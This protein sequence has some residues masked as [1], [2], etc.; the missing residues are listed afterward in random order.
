M[1][2]ENIYNETYEVL[3]NFKMKK[4]SNRSN[5]SGVKK[6]VQWGRNKNTD[7]YDRVGFP[8]E[9]MNFGLVKKRFCNDGNPNIKF[10]QPIQYG[11]NNKK[12]PEIYEQLKKLIEEIDPNFEYDCITIN[13]NFKCRPHYDRNNKSPSLIV[14]FGNYEGG[15]LVIEGEEFDIKNKPLIFNGSI[16]KHWTLEWNGDRFSVIYFKIT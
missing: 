8:C 3:K 16:A 1:C 7:K 15:E 9:S 10:D 11:N 14:G 13:R 5:A 2:L 4:T 6:M 12:Y